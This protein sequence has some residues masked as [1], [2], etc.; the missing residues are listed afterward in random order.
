MR[1]CLRI[2]GSLI[3]VVGL[4]CF[5]VGLQESVA[6]KRGFLEYSLS[7]GD[8]DERLINNIDL[9]RQKT[10]IFFEGIKHSFYG[11]LMIISGIGILLR[12]SWSKLLFL[13]LWSI[14]FLSNI[15]YVIKGQSYFYILILSL[16]IIITSLL[17]FRRQGGTE[18]LKEFT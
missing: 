7:L 2:I 14:I 1:T 16:G 9:E 18:Y 5:L 3:I 10:S 6:I 4:V 15:H 12:C 17:V 11:I 8:K 13:A